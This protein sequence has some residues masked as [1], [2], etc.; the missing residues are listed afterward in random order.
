[1]TEPERA[2]MNGPALEKMYQFLLWLAP[3]VDKMSRSQKFTLG[4]RI[5]NTAL[6]VLEQLIDATYSK[7]A[8]PHLRQVNLG[9][10][11]LRF[12][13]RL[14]SNLRIIDLRR[15][16]HAARAINDVGRLVGGWLK[17]KHA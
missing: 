10:E 15:Y 2:R 11:K 5:Q 8:E 6:T 3:T 17:A 7:P 4:D 1:M 13:F 14:A 12:L 9:L 16:E